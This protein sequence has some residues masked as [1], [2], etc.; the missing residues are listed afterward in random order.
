MEL[1]LHEKS[2]VVYGG[3]KGIGLAIAQQLFNEGANVC[4]VSR[5]EKNLASA[6]KL[7]SQSHRNKFLICRGDLAQKDSILR[8]K[9]FLET[10][11]GSPDIII[12]NSGGP[13]RGSFQDH[14]ETVWVDTFEQHLL[15]LVR[16]LK[17]FSEPMIQKKWGR[18]IN[19]SST[20]ALEP[21]AMMCLSAA[22]RAGVAA[23]SK[24]ASLSL[25]ETGVTINTICPGGVATDRLLSLIIDK[26]SSTGESYEKLLVE[27]AASIP[28][29]RFAEPCEV[30]NL[31]TFL[32]STKADYITGRTHSVDGGLV[33][34]L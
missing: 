15:S 9:T 23:L 34:S 22:M 27:A 30:A 13:P 16:L 14:E 25:A 4:I 24:S 29:K 1:E 2:A 18:F 12:N 17:G 19:V 21:S 32:C 7:I 8:V 26:S 11:I 6:K 5:S 33:K 10:A 3:S 20:V 31:V 28:M